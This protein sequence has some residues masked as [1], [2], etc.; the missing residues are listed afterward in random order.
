MAEEVGFGHVRESPSSQT[1]NA[2]TRISI[3]E[4]LVFFPLS[5]MPPRMLTSQGA[6]NWVQNDCPSVRLVRLNVEL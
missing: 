3:E 1:A 2:A 6:E 5:L 4:S